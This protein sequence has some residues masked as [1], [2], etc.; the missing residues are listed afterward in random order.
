MNIRLISPENKSIP[1]TCIRFEN[2]E[3]GYID[4]TGDSIRV[5]TVYGVPF[6]NIKIKTTRQSG[7]LFDFCLSK[8]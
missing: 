4:T 2:E 1:I 8:D 7:S 5:N 3:G 6:L